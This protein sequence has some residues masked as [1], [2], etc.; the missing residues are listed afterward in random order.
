MTTCCMMLVSMMRT[1]RA[2]T[3]LLERP[4]AINILG[5]DQ[6]TTAL[7]FAGKPDLGDPIVW[8][9]DD[10]SP[11]STGRWDE[12]KQLLFCHGTGAPSPPTLR[13]TPRTDIGEETP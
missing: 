6:L 8:V 2:L 9:V 4:F 5:D 13:T 11:R 1:S 7:Q 12:S 3:Y 10:G